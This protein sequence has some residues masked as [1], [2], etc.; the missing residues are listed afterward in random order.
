MYTNKTKGT[1]FERKVVQGLKKIGWFA[2]RQPRSAFPDIIAI[3]KGETALIIECKMRKYISKKE[4]QDLKEMS[5][6]YG[7]VA[8]AYQ[9]DHPTDKRKKQIVLCSINYKKELL[10]LIK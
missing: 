1:N 4:R 3:K 2:I 5:K 7:N 10:V 8:V 9:R 6:V